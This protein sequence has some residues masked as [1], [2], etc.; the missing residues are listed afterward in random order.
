M[1]F[2]LPTDTKVMPAGMFQVHLVP[3]QRST[4]FASGGLVA[5]SSPSAPTES[6]LTQQPFFSHAEPVHR[7]SEPPLSKPQAVLALMA[8]TCFMPVGRFQVHL[9]PVASHFSTRSESE[10]LVAHSV[11]SEAVEMFATVP[12][13]FCQA[14]PV[15]FQW[16]PAVSSPQT[17]FAF[18]TEICLSVAPWGPGWSTHCGAGAASKSL[19]FM[20][21]FAS[22][23]PPNAT[24]LSVVLTVMPYT[25]RAPGFSHCATILPRAS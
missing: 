7:N 12:P 8:V 22:V 10:G 21:T 25:Y 4:R 20:V 11:P 19:H 6:W 15:H 5:H 18:P 23:C 2:A 17:A 24:V 14:A 9:L 1:F 13:I 3:S 16:K